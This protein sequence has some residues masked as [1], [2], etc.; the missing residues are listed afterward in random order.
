MV[1]AKGPDL[2]LFGTQADLLSCN[3]PESPIC[4]VG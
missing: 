3:N 1:N 2:I 4:M